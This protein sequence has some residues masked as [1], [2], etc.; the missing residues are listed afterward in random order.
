MS[1]NN[2]KFDE[3]GLDIYEHKAIGLNMQNAIKHGGTSHP[4]T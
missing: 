3:E 1:E 2:Y 4:K